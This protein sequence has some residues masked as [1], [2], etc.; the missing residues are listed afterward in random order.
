MK[1]T[2]HGAASEVT[3]SCFLVETDEVRF[4]IDCGMFQGGRDAE[5]RNVSAL[6]FDLKQID[7]VLVSHAHLDHCG[8]LPRLATFG[9]KGPVYATEA[10][11]DLLAIMLKDSAHIQER[12]A[13][14][15]NK[16]LR[17]NPDSARRPGGRPGSRYRREFAPLYTV[18]QAENS[19]RL[20]H[21][22]RYGVEFDPHPTVR[23]RFQDAGHILGSA[24]TEIW[25]REAG[26]TTKL[27][28]SGDLGQ[29]ARPVVRDP[30]PIASA[31]V[32]LIESTYAN[33]LHKNIEATIDE[34]V[35][36]VN[37]TLHRR[38]GNLIVPAFALGRTQDL[39]AI[40]V[41]QTAKG[42]LRDLNVYVDSPLAMRATEIMLQHRE[43]LDESSRI[44]LAAREP[45]AL[46]IRIRF[47]EDVE[48]SKALN[49]IRSGALI[50]AA[51]GMCEGGRIKQHLEHNLSRPECSILF[52]GFQAAGTLGR[53]IVDGARSVRLF[54]KPVSV[55]A[56]VHTLGGLSAHADRDA[57][58][59][60]LRK[61]KS[62]PRQTFV[63]HGEPE[64]ARGFGE[65]IERELHWKTRVPEHA[66]TADC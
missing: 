18:A 42:R 12:E 27:V 5:S 40:L 3:G 36:A 19:L 39:L 4:L 48:E 60:W 16:L 21:G 20:N 25:L 15:R 43:V 30:S 54:N 33:R 44:F 32:L 38:R 11:V 47:I 13:A 23:V 51:S 61:F 41:E 57:L 14:W 28:C 1:I 62:A 7:F 52:T 34:L 63:V 17:E 31:D 66:E 10:T 8:L 9:F 24:I 46:P 56:R 53:R 59:G 45:S 50:I 55:R 26:R 64:T 6:N 65:L 37:D 35:D 2:F 58:L 22:V 49:Q 29:P